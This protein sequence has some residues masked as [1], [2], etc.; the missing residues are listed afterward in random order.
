[1][2]EIGSELKNARE[3]L[4]LTLNEIMDR[5]MIP[6]KQLKALE[7]EK[8]AV[9]PGEVYLIGALRKY[10]TELGLDADELLER[11]KRTKADS[12]EDEEENY[13]RK[14]SNKHKKR[15]KAPV[16]RK[17]LK[18]GRLIGM[19]LILLLL[20]TAFHTLVELYERRQ[21]SPPPSNEQPQNENNLPDELSEE[22]PPEIEPEEQQIPPVQVERDPE[23]DGVRFIVRHADSI[24]AEMSFTGS[25]WIRVLADG[26]NVFAGTLQAGQTNMATATEQLSIRIGNPPVMQLVINEQSVQLP[27]TVSPY[28][29]SIVCAE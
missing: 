28:T 16:K 25:C 14:R 26:D 8:F 27:E 6:K 1:M 11:Y 29:L 7:E 12:N 4:G 18:V 23:A 20:L 17:R 5:T 21:S 19:V 10:A 13:E 2:T 15:V 9:F 22:V 24:K 3:S